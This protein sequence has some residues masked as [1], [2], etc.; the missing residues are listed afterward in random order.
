LKQIITKTK[1]RIKKAEKFRVENAEFFFLNV[2]R[3]QHISHAE[4]VFHSAKPNF[5]PL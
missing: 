2:L 1:N 5:T 3:K 4:G